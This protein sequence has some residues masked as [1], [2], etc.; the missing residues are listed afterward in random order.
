[1]PHTSLITEL[2]RHTGVK[3]NEDE[4]LLQPRTMI[5]VK[6]LVRDRR[7]VVRDNAEEVPV[8]LQIQNASPPRA[9][10]IRDDRLTAVEHS[11]Q[12]HRQ[13]FGAHR[14]QMEEH[15][16]YVYGFNLAL[17]QRFSASG[18]EYMTFPQPPTWTSGSQDPGDD[19]VDMGPGGGDG[20]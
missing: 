7:G 18:D 17:S 12:Q 3:W 2:C 6:G 5:D 4:D 14:R 9:E 13:E 19:D 11:L 16:R 10:Q 20:Q 8:P 1:M 15:M